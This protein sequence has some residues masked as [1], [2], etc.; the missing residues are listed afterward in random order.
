ML[1][2]SSMPAPSPAPFDA[3]LFDL[4]GTLADSAEDIR[5][6]LGLAF[7]DIGVDLSERLVQLVDG[8]PL[9]EIFAVAMPHGRPEQL[10]QFI[11]S[12][13][14]HYE[15]GLST[16]T[17]L[18]PGVRPTL[19]VLAVLRPRIKLAITTSKRQT[20][21]KALAQA[22]E[23]ESIFDAITGS[24]ASLIPPKPAPD[25]LLSTA[26]GLGTS[27]SRTLMVGDTLRDVVAGQ[28]AG[29]RTAVVTYGLGSV[30]ELINA[31]P[32]YV[33]EE[34]EDLLVILGLAA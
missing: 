3:I 33:L 9:E 18:F 25:L 22:L 24:G 32:D 8:S 5:L 30:T 12:Y 14:F 26:Q 16:H 20:T 4:D 2:V 21:A 15:R 23:I 31:R 11:A 34:F 13:R 17:R 6:A 28:R 29:M 19:E 10:E 27:P 1:C 7:N